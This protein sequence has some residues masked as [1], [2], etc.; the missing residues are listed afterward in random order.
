MASRQTWIVSATS[1]FVV[2]A[3]ATLFVG[4]SGGCDD[5][6]PAIDERVGQLGRKVG[7]APDRSGELHRA[8]QE[9]AQASETQLADMATR[10]ERHA[11][12]QD[13]PRESLERLRR[14][15]ALLR[16]QRQAVIEATDSTFDTALTDFETQVNTVREQLDRVAEGPQGPRPSLP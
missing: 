14:D 1:A 15:H 8:R 9:F 3:A 16:E 5:D 6:R 13:I 12:A 11:A 4:R 10:I 2:A 7:E